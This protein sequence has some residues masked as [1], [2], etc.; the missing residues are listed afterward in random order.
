MARIGGRPAA[1]APRA[2]PAAAAGAR[3]GAEMRVIPDPVRGSAWITRQLRQAI[4]EGGYGH[5][6]KLPAERQLAEAFGASRTTVR[7][8]LDQ[9]EA[10][11]LVTR[12]VGSGTFVNARPSQAEEVAELTSPLQLIEVR[13]A[14]EPHMTRL[15]VLN[16]TARDVERL[17]EA[18]AEIEARCADP[19][20]FTLWDESFHL[21]IAEATRNPLMVSVYRQINE[22]RGHAQ[23]NAMKDKVLT[24][25]RM[26]EYNQQHRSLYEA[27]RARDVEGAVAIVTNHLHYARRQLIG[28]GGQ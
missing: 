24:D 2:Q 18:V 15:A 21:L 8:A 11:R 27:I 14:V 1:P 26:A 20:S 19:E 5:G 6:E 7:L 22:V 17:G 23:W 10:E 16:A 4:V 9:L 25:E 28:A 12:R 13:L 3:L